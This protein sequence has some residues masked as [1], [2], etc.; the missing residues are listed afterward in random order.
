[1]KSILYIGENKNNL[2]L[3]GFNSSML[4]SI[5][6]KRTLNNAYS[7]L[8]NSDRLP[9]IIFCEKNKKT[10]P[11]KLIKL[12][13][14]NPRFY[15]IVFV[16][17]GNGMSKKEIQYARDCGVDEVIQSPNKIHFYLDR[18]KFLMQYKTE[19]KSIKK[20]KM[21]GSPKTPFTKRLFDI[22]FA[23]L[24]LVV[25]SPLIILTIIAIKIES[26]GPLFYSAKRVGRE[27]QIF[28]FYKFRSMQIN[29]DEKL[30]DIEGLN[31]YRKGHLN[32]K[33]SFCPN[34]N[35]AMACSP[36]LFI[37]GKEICEQHHHRISK[38]KGASTFIKIKDDPRV[39]R[40]GRFIRNT[41]IDELPQLINVIKG[42]MSIVG[43]R[44]LPLY[45]A[46]LLT[47]D[48][49][50]ERFA[51]P[52]GITGLWQVEKR[53]G[54]EMSEEERKNLD[55]KY[56]KNSSFLYDLKLIIRTIPA[57]MQSENV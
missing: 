28:N 38:L 14:A 11:F 22:V 5:S 50:A 6:Y 40:V 9:K 45:E 12:F 55:N 32:D 15:K 25:I 1:M 16:L 4:N 3:S 30:K 10:N 36:I 41:S 44:P 37:D 35:P 53:G 18:L 21:K 24:I 48:N 27:Y 20:Q 2:I 33:L 52:A 51:A 13:K 56:A 43:N 23:S 19:K 29:A 54:G 26:K 46:E 7:F 47:S 31:Q 57:L 42:D 49:W 8:L 39:T 17:I 34:C